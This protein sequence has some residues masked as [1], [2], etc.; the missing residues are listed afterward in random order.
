[1][2]SCSWTALVLSVV[3]LVGCTAKA[4]LPSYGTV[5]DFQLTDQSN[6]HFSSAASLRGKVWIADFIFT[7]CPGPCPRMSSQMRQ[8]GNALHDLKDLRL[9][10]FTVD[11][12]RDTPEAL[13]KYAAH[14]D[15]QP[16]V[17]FFLTG[18]Q[19]DLHR[20]AK[21][22]FKLGDVDGDLEHSTRFVL[23]DQKSRIRGYYLTSDDD[24]IPH[25]IADAKQISKEPF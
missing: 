16:G 25:V 4:G 18:P 1:M 13:A 14:Y 5:P 17:W 11:P 7:N 19:P 15:A 22:V 6:Q 3:S 24:A 21:D 2:A 8:V 23:V 20:L 12:A 9:V 10:S